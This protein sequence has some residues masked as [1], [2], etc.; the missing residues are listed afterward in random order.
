MEQTYLDDVPLA[1]AFLK[2]DEVSSS[3]RY[4]KVRYQGLEVACK[5]KG[6]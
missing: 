2:P 5:V 3:Y 4:R 6:S 1:H